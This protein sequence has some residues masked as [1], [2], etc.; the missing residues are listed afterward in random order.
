MFETSICFN[1]LC[2]YPFCWSVR[3][4]HMFW[5]NFENSCL[6]EKFMFTSLFGPKHC[7]PGLVVYLSWACCFFGRG[8]TSS[9]CQLSPASG[10]RLHVLVVK[11]YVGSCRRGHVY[12]PWDYGILTDCVVL[13][14]VPCHCSAFFSSAGRQSIQVMPI[15][16]Y[17]HYLKWWNTWKG[18]D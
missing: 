3:S 7:L 13:A 6:F 16:R 18:V 8:G 5:P 4:E 11:R 9:V 14:L 1:L 15:Y 17:S 2:L 10:S 12:V